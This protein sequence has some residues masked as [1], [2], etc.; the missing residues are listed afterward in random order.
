MSFHDEMVVVLRG[1]KAD[2]HISFDFDVEKLEIHD[3][4]F[5][6]HLLQSGKGGFSAAG[7][8]G[9]Y[10]GDGGTITVNGGTVHATAGAEA[11]SIGGGASAED[12]GPVTIS[13][14]ADVTRD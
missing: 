14:S 7:I 3:G 6:F 11:D 10:S 4:S 8:G 12:H 1:V 5:G 2:S 13:D 9:G